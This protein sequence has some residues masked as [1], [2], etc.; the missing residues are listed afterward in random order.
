MRQLRQIRPLCWFTLVWS[1][2]LT[3]LITP[4][5]PN[6]FVLPFALLLV[7]HL[8]VYLIMFSAKTP[9]RSQQVYLVIQALFVMLIS[10]TAQQPA[11]A[12]AFSVWWFVAAV[13]VLK[14]LRP[15]LYA[16]G[17]YILFMFIY[18]NT[19]GSE[20]R[21][22]TL[23]NDN[24]SMA[25]ISL[26]SF[27]L[28]GMVL[29]LQQEHAHKQ[30]Q[31]LLA[32]LNAAHAQLSAYALRVEELTA[33]TERQRIARDLHDTLIQGVAALIMQL[34][35]VQTQMEHQ[36]H[37]RAGEILGQVMDS[38]RDT[39]TDARFAL[40]DLRTGCIRPDELV[41]DVQEELERF[42]AASAIPYYASIAA[43]ACTPAPLCEH[44]LRVITEALNNIARHALAHHVWICV[45]Q[46]YNTLTIEVR[47]DGI[48]FEP[49]TVSTQIG[50]YGLLGI[51]ERARLIGGQLEINSVPGAGTTVRLRLLT[52]HPA[53]QQV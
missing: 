2:F 52:A 49:S 33:L 15:I 17:C 32:Q 45:A 29:Y 40:G 4:I 26:A 5:L 38:A 6:E 36:Q 39:L 42:H 1:I 25:Y 34:E 44:V 48:G 23:W 53:L 14:Q 8:I 31:G 21:W 11:A 43:L 20:L 18:A 16:A 24:N 10:H 19:F 46:A 35:V 30:T 41:E 22:N 28:A 12:V 47:D 51:R 13:D 50:H 9:D 3:V 7:P 27:V 37:R